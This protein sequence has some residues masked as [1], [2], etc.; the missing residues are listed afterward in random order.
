MVEP[1]STVTGMC[2]RLL[3][4]CT[5]DRLNLKL[6]GSKNISSI[7]ACKIADDVGRTVVVAGMDRLPRF[8]RDLVNF[9]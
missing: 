4:L 3:E 2:A 7:P 6:I 5:S 9:G 8:S 1:S